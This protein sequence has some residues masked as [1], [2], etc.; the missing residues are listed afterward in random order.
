MIPALAEIITYKNQCFYRQKSG[1]I[2]DNRLMARFQ[3]RDVGD[4]SAILLGEKNID[5]IIALIVYEVNNLL[6]LSFRRETL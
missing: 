4:I 2:K 1:R 6:F 3:V 5:T